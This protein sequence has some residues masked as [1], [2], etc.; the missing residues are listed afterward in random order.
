MYWTLIVV[1]LC[2]TYQT[3]EAGSS[4]SSMIPNSSGPCNLIALGILTIIFIS[5]NSKYIHINELSNFIDLNEFSGTMLTF[6]T[7]VLPAYSD[8]SNDIIDKINE[9][10]PM[11]GK[12]TSYILLH[13]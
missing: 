2:A 12:Y 8:L 10:K 9:Y 1:V 6:L 4:S 11:I 7:N 5:W 13:R 3:L